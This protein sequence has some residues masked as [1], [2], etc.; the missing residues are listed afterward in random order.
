MHAYKINY[1][2]A[3]HRIR[4]QFYQ[5]YDISAVV[6]CAKLCPGLKYFGMVQLKLTGEV[7]NE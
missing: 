3:G 7:M 4:S 2:N 1:R 5:Y 6:T